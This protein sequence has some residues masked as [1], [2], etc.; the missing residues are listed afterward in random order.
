MR[1]KVLF[2]LILTACSW[3]DRVPS[4]VE[5]GYSGSAEFW[6]GVPYNA[7]WE[8]KAT[9]PSSW[10]ELTPSKGLGPAR[11][12]VRARG[13]RLP[14]APLAETSYRLEGDLSATIRFLQ[15]QVRLT[16]R[17]V[18]TPAP[19][20]SRLPGMGLRPRTLPAPTGEILVKL[21]PGR[22]AL[23]GSLGLR[24]FDPRARVGKLRSSD[25]RLLERLRA[26]PDVEWAEPNGW[27]Q[28][29]G[30]PTDELYPQQWYLRSTGARF[31]YLG[32]FARPVEVAVVDTGVRYDH[33]DLAE[34]LVLPGEGA[35]DFVDG[36]PDPTD[37]GDT[38]R[39]TSGSHGTHVTGIVTARSGA[40]TLPP[41]CYE[42]G[43]P[44]CSQSG[45]VGMAW[46]A[47]VRVLPIRV[48]DAKGNGTF[49]AAA[50]A[51]RYAAGL[52]V[53]WNGQTLQLPQPVSVINLSLGSLQRS[54]ALCDA[55]AEAV[56]Q[57]VLVAAAAGNYQDVEP[58]A[59]FYPASCPGAL[60]VGA[61]DLE[62]R[63]TFY[64]QQNETVALS[65]PGGDT[66]GG[67]AKGI[68]STTWDFNAGRP[69][70]A[71]YMGTS[72]ATP[73]ASAALALLL[74]SDPTLTPAAA[75][76][77]LKARLI[78][79]GTPGRDNAYGYGFLS[80]PTALGLSLPPG[81]LAA[82]LQGPSPH[83]L[84]ADGDGRFSSYVLA[85]AYTLRVCRDDSANGLCDGGE[86]SRDHAVQVP[87][88]PSFE[89]GNLPGP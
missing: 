29:Q 59:P 27:V 82:T 86:P 46:A 32:S 11:I 74:S 18:E 67:P 4:E 89:A 85:G 61:T 6:L 44:V 47:P 1:W 55:V 45:T 84:F 26:N 73:Q 16:G 5:L 41:E 20:A 39:P 31:A 52:A 57:G 56:R 42:G 14:E 78:D 34:R 63:P 13:D 68:L 37:P 60:G 36:D 8:L 69:G 58:G 19:E 48:L 33:P 72:Q 38:L 75:W 76:E 2:L 65:T 9:E 79:L 80:L 88:R 17:L 12:R 71:F 77:R 7:A 87:A 43:Q 83:P 70:Y 24:N 64:S 28:A 40:N 23:L 25:P 54:Q 62:Y 49:E 66:R 53:E 81:P 51:I 21:K 10:L 3:G 35:Y 15:P 30:E 22:R 50:A